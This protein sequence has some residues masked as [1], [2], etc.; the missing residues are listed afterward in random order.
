MSN[1][2][3]VLF[4]WERLGA[5]AL[6]WAVGGSVCAE[7]MVTDFNETQHGLLQELQPNVAG[8]NF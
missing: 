3:L 7:D 6:G 4:R 1:G 5:L 8:V 2:L